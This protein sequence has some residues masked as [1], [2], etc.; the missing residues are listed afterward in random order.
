LWDR[1]LKLGVVTDAHNGNSLNR[2]RKAGSGAFF[3]AVII[4]D[5][6]GKAKPSPEQFLLAMKKAGVTASEGCLSGKAYAG[7]VYR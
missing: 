2:L 5:M 6:Q 4:M 1:G 3:D 7:M